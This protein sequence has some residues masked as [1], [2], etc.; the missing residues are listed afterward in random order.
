MDEFEVLIALLVAIFKLIVWI[1]RTWFRALR[2]LFTL[3]R[4]RPQQRAD[5]ARLAPAPKEKGAPVRTPRPASYVAVRENRVASQ[6][7]IARYKSEWD[8]PPPPP[9]GTPPPPR[10]RRA[11]AAA[12]PLA[13][14]EQGITPEMLR[15]A[16]VLDALLAR[17]R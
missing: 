2:W 12:R 7:D 5:P 17:R 16:I 10:R 6:A 3:G 8:V 14:D 4:L 1:F 9:P 15:D 11:R 13:D